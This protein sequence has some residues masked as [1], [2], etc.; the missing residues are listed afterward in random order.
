M[1][2]SGEILL[3]KYDRTVGR[4]GK[5]SEGFRGRVHETSLL[6]RMIVVGKFID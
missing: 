4:I 5:T 3:I 1:R 6:S 2:N